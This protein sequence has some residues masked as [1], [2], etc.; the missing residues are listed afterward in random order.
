MASGNLPPRQK[1]INMMY[2]VLMAMLA[3][4]MSKKVLSSF[5]YMNEKME[6]STGII[7]KNVELLILNLRKKSS[8]Q[9]KKYKKIY[10]KSIQ[11]QKESDALYEHVGLIK[12]NLLKDIKPENRKNYENMDADSPG[13]VYFFSGEGASKS[14]KEFVK[15]MKAYSENIKNILGKNTTQYKRIKNSLLK[16]FD[17]SDEYHDGAK[18]TWLSS[19][20]E[21]FPLIATL[22]NLSAIQVD[23][24]NTQKEIYNVLLGSQLQ[25]DAAISENTYQAIVI[26]D[27]SVYF[28][29]EMFSAKVVLGRYDENL[30]PE[31]IIVNGSVGRKVGGAS[32]IKFKTG[33]VGEN[34]IVGKFVF[35]QNDKKINIP[36]KSSYTVISKPEKAVVSADKMN[37]V[38][39]GI[40]NPITISLPGVSDNK[41][42]V[43]ANGLR[44]LGGIG[45][46]VLVPS[47]GNNVKINVK[48]DLGDGKKIMTEVFFRIK[49]IPAPVASIR[50]QYG[51]IQLPRSSMQKISVDAKMVDFDF[52]LKIKVIGF[53]MKVPGQS[54][55]VIKGNRMDSKAKRVLNKAKRGDIVNIFDVKAKIMG[56]SSY[57]LKKIMPLSVE[58][59]N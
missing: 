25:L 47:K 23:I 51:N 36:I 52:D 27:K 9:P 24:K 53:K 26:P 16:R 57:K 55:V 14:G 31:K 45:R 10:N 28:E 49:D 35:L 11:I 34:S 2:L 5:G 32:T 8:E 40:E 19:R 29:G 50:G 43:K 59:N 33:N 3:L 20:F 17:I 13:N 7:E 15:K 21:G 39:R 30:V 4:N 12:S 44:K 41:L 6:M 56:N 42:N 37:V 48:A 38:Y 54:T 58:I 46:Y 22:A 1:M 18:K